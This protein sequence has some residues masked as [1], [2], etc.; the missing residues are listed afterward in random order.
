MLDE[1]SD[2]WEYPR[3]ASESE[4]GHLSA[5]IIIQGPGHDGTRLALRE[6]ITSFGRLPS[7]DV[8][9]LGD[10]VSRHHSRI[11][12]FEG[13]AT[14]QDLGSHNGSWVNGERVT[15]RVLHEGDIVRVG[16]FRLSFHEGA[17]GASPGHVAFEETTAAE[18]DESEPQRIEPPRPA[19]AKRRTIPTP[20]PT[21]TADESSESLPGFKQQAPTSSVLIDQIE[22]V[23]EGRTDED[24]DA[25]AQALLLLYRASEALAKA[26]NLRTYIDELLALIL[27]Q[28][29]TE[30]AIFLRIDEDGEPK[31]IAARDRRGSRTDAPV[32]LS[33]VRWVTQ[34]NF[35]VMSEDVRR[36][37]RFDGGGK[38][39]GEDARAVACVPVSTR[40]RVLGALYLSRSSPAFVESELDALCAI[41]HL[42]VVGIERT[43]LREQ[44]LEDGLAREIL[45][46]FHSPDVVEQILKNSN[47]G[48]GP[49]PFLEG[50][51]ATIS[52]C[53]IQGFTALT[54]R[55]PVEEVSEFLNTYFEQ[56]SDI[57][58]RHR[59]TIDKFIGGG[60]MSIFGAP[61]SYG[62]DAARAVAASLEMRDAFDALIRSRPNVG[63]R[64][65]RVGINTGWVLAGTIGSH[66]RLEY[67]AIGDT[68]NAA[69]RLEASAA[70]GAILIGEA[71][72]PLVS[73]LFE[74]RKLGVQQLRGR[75]DPLQVYEVL[76]RRRGSSRVR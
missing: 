33:V 40:K 13:K 52:F 7:N 49:K 53:D 65:L 19:T 61:F 47:P 5:Y 43:E 41:A 17:I 72:Y 4:Q 10:L 74:V 60:V 25:N 32:S 51:T 2:R 56:M 27:E 9:L 36:D 64:R 15:T 3:V 21:R 39:I 68:V 11:T 63:P 66:R 42:S 26:V 71:T 28:I 73:E 59:G 34:K 1:K 37:I 14:L 55:L 12:F 70:P 54:E 8:I 75:A 22:R 50:K 35:A 48:E 45:S 58:L 18:S 38:P 57:T 76:G 69:S 44:M 31:Q 30:H 62:N 20:E 23:R 16:N 67:T 6:G 29:R 24:L 46:R